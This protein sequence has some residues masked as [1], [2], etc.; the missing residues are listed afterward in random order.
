LKITFKSQQQ[1]IS[2]GAMA[3][4]GEKYGDIVRTIAIGDE[5]P[6][7]Y[8]LCGGTHVDETGMIGIFL[9]V[10][11]GSV[12]AGTRRIEAVTGRK[13]YDLVK[14][15][16][17]KLAKAASLVG[18][19]PDNLPEKTTILVDEL[20]QLHKQVASLRHSQTLSEFILKLEQTRQVNGIKVLTARLNDADADTLRQ[21]ADRFRQTNASKAVAVLAGVREG[22]PTIIGAVTEDLL[23]N[24]LNAVDLVRFV[25]SP[26]GGGGGGKPT[27]AQAGGK[28]A[29]N[30]DKAL[31]SVD[32]WL[33]EKLGPAS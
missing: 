18:G 10:S 26:L 6:F 31:E 15:R 12:A 7:S 2:E 20:N 28:D 17:Q 4:F 27:L 24:G 14:Y 25:A 16:F 23:A 13:A 3:L 19:T 33:K 5:Q 32:G 22:R 11:E 1:A 21:M 30:L 29:S 9:I 8:E